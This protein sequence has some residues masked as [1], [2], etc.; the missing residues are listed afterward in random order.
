M[1][2]KILMLLMTAVMLFT[3]TGT[4]FASTPIEVMPNVSEGALPDVPGSPQG[5]EDIQPYT[6]NLTG[7]LNFNGRIAR[8]SGVLIEHGA[9]LKLTMTLKRGSQTLK[10]WT[11]TGT[12]YVGIGEEYAVTSYATYTL[13]YEYWVNGVKQPNVE[14]TNTPPY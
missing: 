7:S 10:S 9:T 4:A 6:N 8:C 11:A 12:D 1:K 14:T 2:K 5:E 13:V 3:V